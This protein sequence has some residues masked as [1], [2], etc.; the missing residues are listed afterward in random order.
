MRCWVILSA[1]FIC[2]DRLP[3]G[4]V[5]PQLGHERTDA[6]HCGLVLWFFWRLCCDS[7]LSSGILLLGG[8]VFGY[9]GFM[10]SRFL[11][12]FGLFGTH[13]VRWRSGLPDFESANRH[14]YCMLTGLL[15]PSWFVEY[16]P[17]CV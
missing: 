15:L 5:L 11:L 1:G 14:Q 9:A 2:A 6:V 8:L 13:A 3:G 16:H 4:L 7:G 17:V 12:S 10:H